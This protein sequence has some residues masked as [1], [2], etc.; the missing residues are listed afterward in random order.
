MLQR[1]REHGRSKRNKLQNCKNMR[2][3]TKSQFV[4]V[5]NRC[6]HQRCES[7]GQEGIAGR[8]EGW[9]AWTDAEKG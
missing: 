6:V 1:T 7:K 4:V 9:E 2:E 5:D 3:K 8:R